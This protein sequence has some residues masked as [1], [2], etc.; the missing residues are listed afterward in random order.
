MGEDSRRRE[1]CDTARVGLVIRADTPATQGLHSRPVQTAPAT[2]NDQGALPMPAAP[3]GRARF[4]AAAP[5]P[6]LLA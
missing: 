6:R 5:T 2:L 3:A 4:H 1:K